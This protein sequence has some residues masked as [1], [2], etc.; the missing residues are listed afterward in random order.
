MP[1][2]DTHSNKNIWT[3]FGLWSRKPERVDV[4]YGVENLV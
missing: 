4:A 2:P 1:I 3:Y